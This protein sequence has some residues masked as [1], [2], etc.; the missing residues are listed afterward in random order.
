MRSTESDWAAGVCAREEGAREAAL[1]ALP[2]VVGGGAEDEAE[3]FM[4]SKLS[5]GSC[6]E[7]EAFWGVFIAR[8]AAAPWASL[9]PLLR[10]RWIRENETGHGERGRRRV[11]VFPD[12]EIEGCGR[13]ADLE[14]LR[15][16]RSSYCRTKMTLECTECGVCRQPQ[17]AAAASEALSHQ[18]GSLLAHGHLLDTYDYT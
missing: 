7:G 1:G 17:P 11:V 18:P 15:A 3:A 8:L 2:L 10:R 5:P 9:V 6:S 12:E 14:S 13:R 16:A 4:A